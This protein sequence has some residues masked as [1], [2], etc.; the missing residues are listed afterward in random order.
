MRLWLPFTQMRCYDPGSRTF[1][2]GFGTM[3]ED[4][5]GHRV[6]DAV[7]SIWTTIHGH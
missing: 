7:S 5:R 1:V 4:A 6:Y 3:L 2:R